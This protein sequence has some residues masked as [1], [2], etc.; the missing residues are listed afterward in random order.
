MIKLLLIIVIVFIP[1]SSRL[2][3]AEL[4]LSTSDIARSVVFLHVPSEKPSAPG[5]QEIGT[6]FLVNINGKLFL[7]TAAHVAK[8]ITGKASMTLAGEN[9]AAQTIALSQLTGISTVPN[10]VIHPT[11]DVAVLPIQ[12]NSELQK[13]LCS[14]ALS[15]IIFISKIEA[16]PRERPLT[17]IG[18]PLGL[19][20]LFTGTEG[21]ISAITKET[22]AASGLLT[23]PRADT[24]KPSEFFVLD[25]PSV[26]G[27]SGA[28][29]FIMP[30]TF[31]TGAA[32]SFSNKTLFVGLV[33]G[34]VSDE[35]G[36]KF[37]LIVPSA[38]VTQ[39][40]EQAYMKSNQQ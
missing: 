35:T 22:R 7:I 12:P 39:T 11:A 2:H 40:L 34:T 10:W 17:V 3:A 13:V 24:K 8:I 9:D 36:G 31:S 23:L 15:P 29:V 28:P 5:Q 4:S 14:R 33:H 30:A 27:F 21:K 6:G 26:G 32:L 19:G 1:I 25:S 38:F 37:A 16:P 18:F 20:V